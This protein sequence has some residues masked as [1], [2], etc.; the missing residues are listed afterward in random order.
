MRPVLTA[1]GTAKT[2]RQDVLSSQCLA[3]RGCPGRAAPTEAPGVLARWA[4]AGRGR[5]RSGQC[6]GRQAAGSG[7]RSE[8]PLPPSVSCSPPRAGGGSGRRRPH[9]RRTCC[10]RRAGAIL[11]NQGLALAW[12][13][14]QPPHHH[15]VLWPRCSLGSRGLSRPLQAEGLLWGTG[16]GVLF[17]SR[18]PSAA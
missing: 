5:S 6:S 8:P 1:E 10:I 15:Q 7:V 11:G 9:S 17:T 3:G 2:M 14:E 13:G 4:G 18:D 16:W 12:P